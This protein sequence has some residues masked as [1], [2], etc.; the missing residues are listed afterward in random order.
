M[1]PSS[2]LLLHQKHFFNTLSRSLNLLLCCVGTSRLAPFLATP[3][4]PTHTPLAVRFDFPA[5]GIRTANCASSVGS[6]AHRDRPRMIRVMRVVEGLERELASPAS[7]RRCVMRALRPRE[8]ILRPTP[9]T[10]PAL[11]LE[12]RAPVGSTSFDACHADPPRVV[13]AERAFTTNPP[14]SDIPCR[15]QAPPTGSIR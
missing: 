6:D 14:T 1:L 11:F 8:S 13:A 7:V 2:L 5:S 15:L 12:A 4:S 9:S 10:E 3:W